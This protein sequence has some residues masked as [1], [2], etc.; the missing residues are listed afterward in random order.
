MTHE[1][2]KSM[3]TKTLDVRVAQ[4][5]FKELLSLV[6]EGNEIVLTQDSMPIA[7]LVPI[8][9]FSSRI[10]GLHSGAINSLDDAYIPDS[11]PQEETNSDDAL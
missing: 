1:L 7:R 8:S 4:Q 9:T 6:A 11:P 5:Y 10:P 3:V 2:Q